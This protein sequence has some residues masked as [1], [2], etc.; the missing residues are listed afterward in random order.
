MDRIWIMVAN[1]SRARVYERDPDSAKLTERSGFIHP[2]SRQK[3]GEL[4]YD[5]AGHTEHGFGTSGRGSTQY[6]PPTDAHERERTK[7]ARE[8]A[9]F[10]EAAVLDHRCPGWMLFASS[11]FLGELKAQLGDA[12]SKAL[13][14]AEPVDLTAWGERELARR[15]I[16]VL[17]AQF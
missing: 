4:Q 1:A 6:E 14:A 7:F 12:A 8:L 5:R 3:V 2:Q 16:D 10:V 11:P 13:I 9:Q 15:V 17:E